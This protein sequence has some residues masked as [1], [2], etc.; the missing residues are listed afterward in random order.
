MGVTEIIAILITLAALFSYIN[1]RFVK[2]PT[3]I[4]L[5]VISL[6]LSLGIIALVLTLPAGEIR[7]S[8][9]VITYVVVIFS[10]IAQGLTIGKLVARK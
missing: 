6:M 3:T 8:L 7:E 5:L 10:I 1:Y 2:L 9:L 4:G